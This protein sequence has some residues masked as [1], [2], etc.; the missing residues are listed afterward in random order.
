[1]VISLFGVC[2]LMQASHGP[3]YTFFTIYLEKF[4]YSRTLIGQL[5][6]L[7]VMAEIGVFLLM[8]RLL[9]RFGARHLLLVPVALTTLRWIMIAGCP[10]IPPWSALPR[11]C[12][13]PASASTTPCRF[14]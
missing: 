9:S 2:F 12:M 5:W 4:G 14:S 11:S 7:G 1:M 6:A 10:V 3:Y 13:P 8:P